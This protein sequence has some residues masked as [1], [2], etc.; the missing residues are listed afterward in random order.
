[1]RAIYAKAHDAGC[2]F[3]EYYTLCSIV[4]DFVAF[5][6]LLKL[7]NRLIHTSNVTTYPSVLTIALRMSILPFCTVVELGDIQYYISCNCYLIC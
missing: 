6:S 3:S 5:E 2:I 7:S 1:M 4:N